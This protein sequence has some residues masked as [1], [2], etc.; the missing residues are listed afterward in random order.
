[1]DE[2]RLGLKPIRR[3]QWVRRGRDFRVE[4][5]PRYQWT[6][7]FGFVRPTTGRVFFTLMPSVG[8][9]EMAT[10]LHAFARHVRAG[11]HRRIVLVLDGAGWHSGALELP[12]GLYLVPLPAYSPELQPAGRLWPLLD[13]PLVNRAVRDLDELEDRICRRCC[14]LR[15][16]RAEVCA[17]TCF[18][19]WRHLDHSA[20]FLK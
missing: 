10:T 5:W 2:H 20:P 14:V 3:G 16:M 9:A 15:T 18:Y 4:V 11:V 19:W 13:E 17:L 8:L 1:M 12:E 7:V 6:W